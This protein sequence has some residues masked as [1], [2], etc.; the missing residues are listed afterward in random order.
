[1]IVLNQT[2]ARIVEIDTPTAIERRIA[3]FKRNFLTAIQ[4]KSIQLMLDIAIADRM[5]INL[6]QEN[7]TAVNFFNWQPEVKKCLDP[8]NCPLITDGQIFQ[9]DNTT[10]IHANRV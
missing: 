10:A 4:Q 8:F 2:V 6:M 9:C 5:D 3:V 1:M 7:R